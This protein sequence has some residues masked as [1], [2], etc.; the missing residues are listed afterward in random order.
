MARRQSSF[1]FAAAACHYIA[2]VGAGFVIFVVSVWLSRAASGANLDDVNPSGCAFLPAYR[3]RPNAKYLWIIPVHDGVNMS[4]NASWCAEML[5]LQREE[6]LVL[7]MHG[8]HHTPH[9][10]GRREFEG[11]TLDEARQLLTLGVAVW[12]DAFG[13]APTHFS[14]PG[15]WATP[16]I[17]PMLRDE[18]HFTHVRSLIDGLLHRIYH[19][20]DAFCGSA[21]FMC[22]DW[23]VDWF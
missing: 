13:A 1:S 15:E 4:A 21:A 6:G 22:R 2:A 12:R 8:V 3:Q 20:D 9:A 10:D 7:G 11:L 18:F 23:A 5:R 16:A 14:F 19:C 17:V